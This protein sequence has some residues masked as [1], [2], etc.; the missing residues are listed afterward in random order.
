MVLLIFFLN[1][2]VIPKT[3]KKQVTNFKSTY[4]H[5]PQKAYLVLQQH[6]R[7]L[8]LI[9]TTDTNLKKLQLLFDY[10]TFLFSEL[11]HM[12]R[13]LL[14]YQHILSLSHIHT[15]TY[16]QKPFK[17][18]FKLKITFLPN[19]FIQFYKYLFVYNLLFDCW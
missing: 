14:S 8:L 17:L 13:S 16:I 10:F 1:T 5:L 11:M 6:Q 18:K 7:N 9:T 15:H 19:L 3:N 2:S 12:N 4:I